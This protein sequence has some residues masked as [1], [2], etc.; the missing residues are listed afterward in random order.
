MTRRCLVV[1]LFAAL[2][3]AAPSVAATTIDG[4]CQASIAGV[5][6]ADKGTDPTSD[7]IPVDEDATIRV[8][9]SAAKPIEHLTVSLEF[10]GR[11]WTVHDRPTAG[12]SWTSMIDVSDYADYGVGLYKV[13]G[14]SSGSG[15][16]CSGAALVDVQGDPLTTIAGLAGLGMAILGGLGVTLLALG[17]RASF[18]RRIGGL[19]LGVIFAAGLGTLLQQYAI[20]YP[21]Q[22][23]A[24]VLLAGGAVLGLL[25]PGLRRLISPA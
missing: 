2:A 16:E 17:G 1:A 8:S 22:T 10:A 15:L 24:I 20:L 14:S 25:L 11:S 4:P 23:V 12:T 7:A 13:V 5:N 6:V 3:L 18:G 9:M 21:T 19:V